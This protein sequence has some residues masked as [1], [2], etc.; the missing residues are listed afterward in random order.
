MHNRTIDFIVVSE[1]ATMS[2]CLELIGFI[3]TILCFAWTQLAQTRRQ[4]TEEAE[5]AKFLQSP[6]DPKALQKWEKERERL[7][8]ERAAFLG[9]FEKDERRHEM[10]QFYKQVRS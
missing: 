2:V 10:D 5:R 7:S 9:T 4:Q 8:N 3:G 6:D 1:E